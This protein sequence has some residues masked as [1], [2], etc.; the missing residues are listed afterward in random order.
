MAGHQGF[1][2]ENKLNG[3]QARGLVRLSQ[4]DRP[5]TKAQRA[6]NRLV[7]RVEELRARLE[8]ETRRLDNALA[9]YGKYLHPRLQRQKGLR[10]DV[11][12]GLAPFL[13]DKRLNGKKER[14][15]L[16]M[17]IA[18]QISDIVAEEG[19]LTDSDL[20]EL[21][22]RIHGVDFEQA[23]REEIEETRSAMEAI[24]DEIGI[25]I[26]L[27]GLRPDMS[28][29]AVAAKAAEMAEK[30]QQKAIEEDYAFGRTERRKTKRQIE[31]AELLRQSEQLRKKSISTIYKQLAK[32]LH[33]DLE[34]DVARRERKVLL[35]QE[36][37][38]AYR[39]NDLHTLLRLEL[40]W[41]QREDGDVERLTE[42]KLAIY[43]QGLKEQIVE[44]EQE[45]AD[46]PFHPRYQ[47]LAV[48]DGV[49][50]IQ[51]RTNGPAEAHWL[52]EVNTTLEASIARLKTDQ[53]IDEVRDLI[54]EYRSA[55][56][57]I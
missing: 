8:A 53:A 29:A 19:T 30:I 26:D 38:T 24:F 20:Q 52:D 5:L 11:V 33:P 21:F 47:P 54:R 12:R 9:Y 42:E 56:R 57:S 2:F 16:R 13:D 6:F 18:E 37:T 17:I 1:L 41:I 51:V 48:P 25:D 44:L 27:S 14:K 36:L 23:E 10:K 45:L 34:Q 31:K 46:L 40:D 15:T 49:F 39:K 28:E 43:N 35:M 32:V 3:P 4:P 7:S 22:E 55:G 50:G